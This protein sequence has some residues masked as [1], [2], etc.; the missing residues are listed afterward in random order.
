MFPAITSP[1]AALPS[2]VS[3]KDNCDYRHDN[4]DGDNDD[5]DNHKD[6]NNDNLNQVNYTAGLAIKRWF[7]ETVAGTLSLR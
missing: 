5:D 4:C 7:E 3:S 6:G 2:S 1:M